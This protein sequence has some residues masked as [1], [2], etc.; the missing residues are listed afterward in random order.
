MQAKPVQKKRVVN[1]KMGR[2]RR[3]KNVSVYRLQVRVEDV[4]LTIFE[5]AAA[6]CGVSHVST[7]LREIGL[8]A[9]AELKRSGKRRIIITS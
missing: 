6:Q 3:G 1:H 2:P 9:A 5:T 8:Q 4:E 7:W